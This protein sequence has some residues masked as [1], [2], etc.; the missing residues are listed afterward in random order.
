M[1]LDVAIYLD[2]SISVYGAVAIFDM[3]GVSWLHA[4]QMTPTVVKR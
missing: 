4:L 1:V 2:E 3:K